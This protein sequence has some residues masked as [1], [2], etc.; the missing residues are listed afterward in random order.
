MKHA[1]AQNVNDLG[2][3]LLCAI[4]KAH[5]AILDQST[6]A[7]DAGCTSFCGGMVVPSGNKKALIAFATGDIDLYVWSKKKRKVVK[8]T[9]VFF[10][11]EHTGETGSLGPYHGNGSPNLCDLQL[12]Q[13]PPPLIIDFIEYVHLMI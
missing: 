4:S 3:Q 10:N 13:K 12:Y 2:Q 5:D 8:S 7:L 11:R 6:P 9:S 1:K